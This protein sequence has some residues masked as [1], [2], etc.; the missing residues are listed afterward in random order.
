M[1]E[2]S[3]D[4]AALLSRQLIYALCLLGRDKKGRSLCAATVSS[5]GRHVFAVKSMDTGS[6]IKETK[7]LLR[8]VRS[9]VVRM[10]VWW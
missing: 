2:H 9:G 5:D 3:I 4:G 6:H 8:H 7:S 10:V 1:R